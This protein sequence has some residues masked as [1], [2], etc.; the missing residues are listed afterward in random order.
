MRNKRI[1]IPCLN[2]FVIQSFI[3]AT[4][5]SHSLHYIHTFELLAI[6]ELQMGLFLNVFLT[7]SE[8]AEHAEPILALT[9]N[10]KLQVHFLLILNKRNSLLNDFIKYGC[11][12]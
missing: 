12:L 6:S 11:A 1:C 8:R 4:S 5:I 10:T 2:K 3:Y 7:A 9:T